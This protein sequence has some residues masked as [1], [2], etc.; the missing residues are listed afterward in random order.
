M[1]EWIAV[2]L[3]AA[4]IVVA[5]RVP[6]QPGQLYSFDSVNFAY[7]IGEFDIERSQPQ[8]PG[9]PLF[10]ME[11]RLL[12]VLRFKRPES[13][14]SALR[15]AGSIAVLMLVYWV[16][17][18]VF[19]RRSAILAVL[20]F[21]IYPAFYFAGLTSAVRVQLAVVALAVAGSCWGAWSGDRRAAMWSSVLLGLG[22]GIRPELGPLLLP[23][24]AAGVMRAAGDWRS[25]IKLTGVLA[26]L[27]AAWFLPTAL[28]SGGV[29]RYVRLN[30]AY[31]SS[32]SAGL[33]SGLLGADD[34]TW[35][36]T[37]VWLLVWT[38]CGLFGLTLAA[39]L[40]GKALTRIQ[41]AFMA[42]WFVPPLVFS[43]F[44]HVADPGHVLAIVPVI[45]IIGGRLIAKGAERFSTAISNAHALVLLAFPAVLVWVWLTMRPESLL[46][47]VAMG[48][49]AGGLLLRWRR[50]EHSWIPRWQAEA[51]LLAPS[52][53]VFSFIWFHKNWF[54]M[55]KSGD[56]REKV[57]QHLHSGLALQTLHQVRGVTWGDDHTLARIRELTIGHSNPMVVWKSGMIEWR[58]VQYY[59]PQVPIWVLERNGVAKLVRGPHLVSVGKQ[60]V[61]FPKGARLIWLERT[62]VRHE[63]VPGEER[64][65]K[66]GS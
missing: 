30:W 35:L 16:G 32:E 47:A 54:Y 34:A 21:A 48:G 28:A 15:L 14:L 24:W 66:L 10:V 56:F 33:T 45:A 46:Y 27:V 25:R 5:T 1:K 50:S 3:L 64:V 29:A 63:D 11:T 42:T 36:M 41:V 20:L 39:V 59:M 57:R 38:L 65:V 62:G 61:R 31:L 53:L 6:Y 23:L 40:G 17:R 58:K 13:V 26:A 52:L 19:D 44:V 7:A 37:V 22:S 43:A 12:S 55:A 18:R 2:A 4:A 51:I 60:P 8:P 9:Y 49:L